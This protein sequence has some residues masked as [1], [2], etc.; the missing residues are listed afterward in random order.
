MDFIYLA[1]Y[2]CH[3]NDTLARLEQAL[4]AWFANRQFFVN[5]GIR[6]D[7]NVPKFHALLHYVLAIQFLGVTANYNTEA[8]KQFH[9]D[10]AKK[11][12]RASNSRDEFKQMTRWLSRQEAVNGMGHF[13]SWAGE[14]CECG[15]PEIPN[16]APPSSPQILLSKFPSVSKQPLSEI[17]CLH[18]VPHF[19]T[20]LRYFIH[21]A[22]GDLCDSQKS[23][24]DYP[25]LLKTLDIYHNLKILQQTLDGGEP[26]IELVKA[27]PCA[28]HFDTV[29]VITD[30]K[31]ESTGLAGAC[32]RFSNIY[33]PL[34]YF[35][36]H[37]Y[38]KSLCHLQAPQYHSLSWSW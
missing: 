17:Q 2:L 20:H 7:F 10:F 19:T 25:F 1:Q 34:T 4:Q 15:F 5:V 18:H 9:I 21:L 26:G 24:D 27:S 36:R 30:S 33:Q 6:N 14:I 3:D 13:L 35:V 11:G 32:I 23:P 31:V 16:D 8:F 37:P 29:V 22:K 38:C 28:G 12:W